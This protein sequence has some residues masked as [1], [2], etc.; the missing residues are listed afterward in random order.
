MTGAKRHPSPSIQAVLAYISHL[1][2]L[3][4]NG[5]QVEKCYRSGSSGGYRDNLAC[6]GR[7]GDILGYDRL[8]DPLFVVEHDLFCELGGRLLLYRGELQLNLSLDQ[9]HQ[10]EQCRRCLVLMQLDFILRVIHS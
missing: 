5:D 3:G 4:A 6:S 2:H 10:L 7:H 1:N 8:E 9:L